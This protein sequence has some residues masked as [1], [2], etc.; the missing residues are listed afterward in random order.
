M[1]QRG[2]TPAETDTQKAA[3]EMKRAID[4]TVAAEKSNGHFGTEQGKQ[5]AAHD[6][7]KN[8]EEAT[9]KPATS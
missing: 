6:L 5:D 2:Q 8:A 3:D 7:K 4:K 1:K 9:G